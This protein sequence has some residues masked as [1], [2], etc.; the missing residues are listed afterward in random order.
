MGDTSIAEAKWTNRPWRGRGRGMSIDTHALVPRRALRPSFVTTFSAAI[1][2]VATACG[3]NV[4]SSGGTAA[5]DGSVESS[6]GSEVCPAQ[7]PSN[8]TACNVDSSLHCDWTHKCGF[9]SSGSC[10]LGQ[11]NISAYNPP[12]PGCPTS[13]PVSGAPCTCDYAQGGCPYPNGMCNG[14]LQ[15]VLASCM[16]GSTWQ[17]EVPTCNPPA[18]F[19]AGT[20]DANTPVDAAAPGDSAAD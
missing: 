4:S 17:I 2:T 14:K 19:D 7:L 5:G 11:W 15:Y 20:P 12:A 10:D 16:P 1:A 13:L 9:E 3:G 8:G 6:D 18:V